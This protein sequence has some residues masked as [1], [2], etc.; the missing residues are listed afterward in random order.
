MYFYVLFDLDIIMLNVDQI[1][2]DNLL[3]KVDDCCHFVLNEA[4]VHWAFA[5]F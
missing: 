5:K 3:L 2:N 1:P 4:L